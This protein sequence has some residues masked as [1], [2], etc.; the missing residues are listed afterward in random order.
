MYSLQWRGGINKYTIKCR[1][2]FFFVSQKNSGIPK[3]NI[4][5][6]F[7]S[8]ESMPHLVRARYAIEVP[9]A[10]SLQKWASKRKRSHYRLVQ[11]YNTKFLQMP[12]STPFFESQDP[13]IFHTCLVC[14]CRAFNE[15]FCFVLFFSSDIWGFV[16]FLEYL[17]LKETPHFRRKKKK[18]P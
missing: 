11:A 4:G 1:T 17:G 8:I 12:T 6:V 3:K 15:W 2:F 14:P 5:T 18:N 16:F 9:H 10:R 7:A 13:E